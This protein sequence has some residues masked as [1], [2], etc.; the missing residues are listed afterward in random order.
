MCPAPGMKLP[1]VWAVRGS[2]YHDASESGAAV[3]RAESCAPADAATIANSVA[4]AA[5]RALAEA[6]EDMLVMLSRVL[7]L[8]K[9]I[10]SSLHAARWHERCPPVRHDAIRISCFPRAIHAER[11]AGVR[12]SRRSSRLRVRVLLR[13]LSS[14]DGGAGPEWFRLVLARRGPPGDDTL[15]R[16]RQRARRSLSP[17]DHRPGRRDPRR[18]VP[19]PV[20]V[21]D[22]ERRSAQRGD[23]G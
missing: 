6:K 21:R 17:G 3:T 14:V 19:G 18:D 20:L 9:L 15:V 13:P 22:R 8:G 4:I 5:P 7:A 12:H 2:R 23:H 1:S 10:T 16:H 11:P